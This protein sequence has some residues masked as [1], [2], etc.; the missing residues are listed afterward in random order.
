MKDKNVN[1]IRN[2]INRSILNNRRAVKGSPFII[3]N[4]FKRG[5]ERKACKF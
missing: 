2:Y 5:F 4:I 3:Q 1:K